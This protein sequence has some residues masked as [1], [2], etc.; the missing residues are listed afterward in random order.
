M[1]LY[2]IALIPPSEV[3]GRIHSLKQ[4]MSRRFGASKALR[5][6]AHITVQIPFWFREQEELSLLQ[7]LENFA[8]EM[9]PFKVELSGFGSFP[10]RVLF[11]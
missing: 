8:Q 5:L 10:P 1:K 3:E 7:I 6:P 2:F 9:Q 11:V 4:E